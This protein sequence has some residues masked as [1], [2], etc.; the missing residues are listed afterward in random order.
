MSCCIEILLLQLI[1]QL[2]ELGRLVLTRLPWCLQICV[3]LVVDMGVGCLL[4]IAPIIF[5][6]R[7]GLLIALWLHR[8]PPKSFA[9][10][11][12]GRNKSNDRK[13][14]ATPA[15]VPSTGHGLLLAAPENL[16]T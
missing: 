14:S 12:D 5:H 8:L 16:P 6:P 13:V 11:I 4:S 15:M 3:S 9:V 7:A 10:W 1:L 2:F